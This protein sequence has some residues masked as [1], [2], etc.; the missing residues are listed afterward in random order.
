[1]RLIIEAGTAINETQTQVKRLQGI[2]AAG[3]VHRLARQTLL[4]TRDKIPPATSVTGGI[5]KQLL[6]VRREGFNLL[7]T[8][9]SPKPLKQLSLYTKT[10]KVACSFLGN[11]ACATKDVDI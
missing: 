8:L 2:P 9:L 10:F 3:A 7:A 11:S 1:M 5:S 6:P 4:P